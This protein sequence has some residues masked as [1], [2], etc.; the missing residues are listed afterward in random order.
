M[1]YKKWVLLGAIFL[2]A[3]VLRFY[4]LGEIP[5]GLYQDE[6]AIGYNA[7][8]ILQTGRDEYGKWFPLYFQSFGDFKLPLYIYSTAA[9]ISIFG[10]SEL[11][12]RF[13]SAF[14]SFLTVILCYLFVRDLTRNKN[15][16]VVA[17][18]FLGINPWHIHYGRA[19]F[20]VSI[21]L[22]FILLGAF[23]L[24]RA[25]KFKSPG[26]FLF[27]TTAFIISLYG[28]NLTRLLSPLLYFAILYFHL[29]EVKIYNKKELWLTLIV[30]ILLLTPFL[31]TFFEGGGVSSA[32]GTLI[33]SSNAVL[34]PLLEFRSYIVETPS[35][36]GIFFFNKWV[37]ISWQ[38]LTNI[39][40]Y[41]SVEFFFLTG[42]AHGNHGIGT[43]GQ[44]YIFDL[45]FFLFGVVWLY[46]KKER[47]GY[48]LLL[49]ILTV[50]FVASLTR[51]APHATRSF[52]LIMP[53]VIISAI[54]LVEGFYFISIKRISRHLKYGIFAFI[55]LIS[56]YSIIYYLTSYY[57]RF[58]IAYAKAWRTEDKNLSLYIKAHEK[59]YEKIIFD[60]DAGFVYTSLLFYNLYPP[61][62][63]QNSVRR[64]L[65]DKEGFT[66][67]KS[68]GKYEFRK[69]EWERDLADTKTLIITNKSN[70]PDNLPTLIEF[71]YPKRPV[72]FSVKEE[73]VQYP[74]DDVAYVLVETK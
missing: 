31:K 59:K 36:F 12:V 11:A 32:T 56:A 53:L 51:E 57:I 3:F 25:F 9:S 30:S 7:Y 21:C 48:L 60:E 43:V 70:K 24:N 55:I 74:V 29:N 63:F 13:P 61:A 17:T 23:F 2:I 46:H 40:S 73:L 44:F 69:I 10:V 22:F 39:F 41:L 45:L 66:P 50:I 33:F 34:A 65:P 26:F 14:F 28:Y 52:F 19:T 5:N 27:G 58:P 6:T 1:K 54:G 67:V 62:D 16:A 42:S 18:L 8:S 72:V 68:F 38:Y 20:E 37:M 71:Y 49:W 15:I 47:W 35:F 4:K 64:S